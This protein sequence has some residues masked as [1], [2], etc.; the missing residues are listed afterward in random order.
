MSLREQWY[1]AR[2]QRQQEV[3]ERQ[4]QVLLTRMQFQAEMAALH[5]YQRAMLS[6]FCQ[7][8]AMETAEFLSATT[9]NRAAM[10]AA[11]REYLS[12]FYSVLQAD[13]A[14]FREETRSH[15]LQVWQEQRQQRA[16]YV[17]AMRNYVWGTT[18][19]PISEQHL[20][21]ATPTNEMGGYQL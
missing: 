5:E 10:A 4:Q 16:A 18:P 21:S 3:R 2:Q 7:N 14:A 9:A 6:Q 11:M 13:V 19:I 12:N 17:A 20:Y 15:Q 8:L 1:A